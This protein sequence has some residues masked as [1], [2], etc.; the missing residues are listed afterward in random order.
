MTLREVRE[1]LGFKPPNIFRKEQKKKMAELAE[2]PRY[3]KEGAAEL[4]KRQMG[5]TTEMVLRAVHEASKGN[6]V[7]ITGRNN[8]LFRD[9]ARSWCHRLS[10]D[11]KLIVS[12]VP[13]YAH[14]PCKILTDHTCRC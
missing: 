13:E 6:K 3:T 14:P 2:D 11:P 1:K 10:V 8:K 12:K 7:F 5:R 9:M 4:R